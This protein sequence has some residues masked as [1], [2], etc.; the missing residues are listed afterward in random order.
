MNKVHAVITGTG[1][2]IPLLKKA[3]KD[4]TAQ[5]FYD[6]QGQ[7][8]QQSGEIIVQKFEQITGIRERRYASH[9]MDASGMASMAALRAIESAG[10]DAETIDQIIVAHNFGD[11]GI[12]STSSSAVPA[13]A[14]RVKHQLG[15]RNAGCI[16]YDLLFGCPGWLQGVIQANAFIQSGMAK[17]C[18]VIGTETL[19]RV[20]D[21]YD[22]DSMIFSD[23]AGAVVVEAKEY[24]DV[25][26]VYG[27]LGASVQ[28]FTAGELN[29]INMA[30]S[31]FSN[32]NQCTQ[33]IKMRGRKVYEFAVKYV[34]AAIK[35]CLTN[36]N[37]DITEVKKIF[38]HQAN[39]KMDAAIINELYKLYDLEADLADIMP[40]NIH[41]LGN[42]S[43]ATI[44]TLF[45]MVCKGELPGHHIHKGDLLVFASVG[46]GMN[47]NAV[48]Y[49]A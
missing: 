15:I 34:P 16:P 18:L 29:Y 30:S 40:M 37:I 24:R 45:D 39:E 1:S 36:C 49:K 26:E 8:I 4:F 38:I 46:A 14:S 44:P 20:I 48:C 7:Q 41:C 22:R 6:D 12:E 31:N 10:I 2:Y 3:N 47:I 17:K 33:Y 13:I 43:V 28:S 42:S 21:V 11:I 5:D 32:N 19:S 25:A 35:Q 23:G 27:F 9:D